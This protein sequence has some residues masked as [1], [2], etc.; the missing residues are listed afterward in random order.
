MEYKTEKTVTYTCTSSWNLED[1]MKEKESVYR[2]EYLI[3]ELR[4]LEENTPDDKHQTKETLN[5]AIAM[6]KAYKISLLE[7]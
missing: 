5:F 4:I 6:L 1:N 7:D 2:I 3:S